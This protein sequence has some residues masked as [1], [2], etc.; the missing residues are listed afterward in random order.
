MT[1]RS[2]GSI[3]RAKLVRILGMLGSD[4]AGEI[5]AAGRAAHKLVCAAGLGWHDM[6]LPALAPPRPAL[7]ANPPSDLLTLLQRWPASWR[8]VAVACAP[9][10]AGMSRQTRDLVYSLTTW[11][12]NP[13][14]KQL[15]WLHHLAEWILSGG[16][17]P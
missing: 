10:T 3:D 4:H 12:T 15:A 5:A 13:T 1:P 14:K 9:S 17:A 6:I 11:R 8:E 2:G 16:R 7:H